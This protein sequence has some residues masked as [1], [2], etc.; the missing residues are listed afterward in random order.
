M[1]VNSIEKKDISFNGFWNSKGVKNMLSFASDSGALFAATTTLVL[2]STVRPLAVWA[3]PKTD[4]ENKKIACAKYI[5]SGICEFLLTLAISLPIVSALKRIDK[6]PQKYLQQ[7]SI[8]FIKDGAENIAD[9]KTYSLMTQLFKLGVGF[10]VVLPKAVL[11][12]LGIPYVLDKYFKTKYAP[13][14]NELKPE[15]ET[16][17][18]LTF[19]GKGSENLAKGIGNILDNK[20][21]QEFSKKYKDSNFPLHIF[22]LKDILA[23]GAFIY[24]ANNNKKINDE[25]KPFLIKNS[26]ISTALS[27]FSTYTIDK[28]TDK[29]AQNIKQKIITENKN[30]PKLAKYLEGF[31]IIKPI[32]IMSTVYYTIIPFVSTYLAQRAER[33]K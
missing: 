2:S 21:L 28:L 19:Q 22:T 1:K 12:T 31:K 8:N 10:M 24:Q 15:K 33:N 11:T 9:S 26:I 13:E 27:I 6:S 23:T 30:D 32:V 3:T 5:S 4:S 25:Q 18:G 16:S 7:K 17:Y 14:N 20:S 29:F